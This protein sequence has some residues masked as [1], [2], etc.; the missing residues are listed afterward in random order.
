MRLVHPGFSQAKTNNAGDKI[1][2][3]SHE[4]LFFSLDPKRIKTVA[5]EEWRVFSGSSSQCITR[6]T[7]SIALYID[8]LHH[9]D[10]ARLLLILFLSLFCF[11]LSERPFICLFF[12]LSLDSH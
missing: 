6:S 9:M 8:S 3:K 1:S 7:V 12:A 10:S 5:I 2:N 11:I 4:T